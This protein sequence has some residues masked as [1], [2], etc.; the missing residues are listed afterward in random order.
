MYSMLPVSYISE[1]KSAKVLHSA[2]FM[3]ATLVQ[4]AGDKGFDVKP[5]AIVTETLLYPDS[6]T[7]VR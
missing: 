5:L 4:V 1:V 2:G 3:A 7:G 6:N